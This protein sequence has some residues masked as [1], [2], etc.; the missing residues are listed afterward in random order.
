MLN[1]TGGTLRRQD[2]NGP[3]PRQCRLV[4]KSG[5]QLLLE[6]HSAPLYGFVR[7]LM[8]VGAVEREKV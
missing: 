3:V 1:I 5:G 4:L 2:D 6:K 8:P 7:P